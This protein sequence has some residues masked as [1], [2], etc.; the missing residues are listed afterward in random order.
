MLEQAI[1]ELTLEV[2]KLR[3]ALERL[4]GTFSSLPESPVPLLLRP[5]EAAKLLGMSRAKIYELMASGELP[6]IRFG[7]SVR[8]PRE[9]LDQVISRRSNG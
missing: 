3:E 4:S 8:I 6:T 9:A 2:R 5:A 7:R 1:V